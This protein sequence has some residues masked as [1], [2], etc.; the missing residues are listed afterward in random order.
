VAVVLGGPQVSFRVEEA[1]AHAPFVVR[2]E[3]QQTILEL[4]AALERG[5]RLDGIAG[6]LGATAW[7]RPITIPLDHV[8]GKPSSSASRSPTSP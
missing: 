2:G 5:A 7:A 8:A 6:F 4:V 1:L 3:G